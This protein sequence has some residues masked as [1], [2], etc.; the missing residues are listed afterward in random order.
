MKI[1]S[2]GRTLEK[3]ALRPVVRRV[4][5]FFRAAGDHDRITALERRVEQLECLFR[6]QAGL[7]YLRLAAE[8]DAGDGAEVLTAGRRTA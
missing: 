7:Q 8:D 3:K 2:L 6:E 4:K 1:A 5:R